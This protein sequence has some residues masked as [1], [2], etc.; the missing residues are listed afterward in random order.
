MSFKHINVFKYDK[1]YEGNANKKHKVV[2]LQAIET[3][4]SSIKMVTK[5]QKASISMSM[6][7]IGTFCVLSVLLCSHLKVSIITLYGFVIPHF[8]I[9]TN[10]L[11]TK[12]DCLHK[13]ALNY[14]G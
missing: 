4:F 2:S 9:Y 1:P 13:K 10:G 8:N 14:W 5:S 6:K 12:S 11:K 3:G 7:K